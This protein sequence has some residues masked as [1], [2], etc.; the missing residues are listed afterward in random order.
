MKQLKYALALLLC[1]S[2]F[3]GCSDDNQPEIYTMTMTEIMSSDGGSVTKTDQYTYI[4]KLLTSHI[5]TQSFSDQ[6]LSHDVS[7]T[8]SGNV[9]TLTYS[10]GNTAI[11]TLDANGCATQCVYQ[12]ASQTRQ[13]QFTYSDGYLTQVDESIDGVPFMSNTLRYKDGDLTSVATGSNEMTCTPGTTLN[14]SELPDLL[15]ANIYPLS[16]HQDALYA[17][18]LGKATCHFTDSFVP[19]IENPDESTQYTY[20]VGKSGNVEKIDEKL[21]Y[22]GIVVDIKGN[23][24]QTTTTAEKSIF[25]AYN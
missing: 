8:Y 19:A 23:E 3:C 2:L 7:F 5:T 6:S 14:T 21:T 22:T 13:Y 11:Y 25:I 4:D 20:T 10:E 24:T 16:L 17:H 12:L 9:V 15:L 1:T 18:I